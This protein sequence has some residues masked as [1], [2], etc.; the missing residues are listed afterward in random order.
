MKDFEN[1]SCCLLQNA[2]VSYFVLVKGA[3]DSMKPYTPTSASGFF[4]IIFLRIDF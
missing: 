3:D 1:N 4:S 2:A